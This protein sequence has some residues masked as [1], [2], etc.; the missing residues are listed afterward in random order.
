GRLYT[1]DYGAYDKKKYTPLK[2]VVCTFSKTNG[3]SGYKNKKILNRTYADTLELNGR[4]IIDFYMC[5]FCDRY[6][7]PHL[8]E[9]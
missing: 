4:Y 9:R 8:R 1:T 3:T 7:Q 6:H 2:I 5:G